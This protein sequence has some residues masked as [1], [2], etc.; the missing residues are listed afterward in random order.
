M[1]A[2]V[3]AGAAL[4]A[5][6]A[7][8]AAL[9]CS[10]P[11]GD[12]RFTAA[13]G[14]SSALRVSRIDGSRHYR[15]APA[16]GIAATGI[17]HLREP[18]TVAA[19]Q[20]LYLQYRATVAEA[21]VSVLDDRDREVARYRLQ[22]GGQA[23]IRRYLP[24]P[25][26][27]LWGFRLWTEEP[28]GRLDLTAAGVAAGRSGVAM[29]DGVLHVGVDVLLPRGT[30]V[31][32]G[33]LTALTARLQTARST[34]Q[35]G[36]GLVVRSTFIPDSAGGVGELL[37]AVSGG[38][39]AS[40]RRAIVA[41]VLAEGE[42]LVHL[43]EPVLGFV[44]TGV[45]A[46]SYT[47]GSVRFVELHRAAID[48]APLPADLKAILAYP[49]SAWRGADWEVFRWTALAEVLIFDTASYRIQEALFRRLA[50]FVEKAGFRGRVAS[51]AELAGRYGYNAHDYAAADVARFFTV[52]A[53][54]G[55]QLND[56]ELW[57]RDF[58]VA[59]GVI[60]TVGGTWEAG[61]GAVL[62]ISRESSPTLR[63]LLLRHEAAHG[64]YFVR[65]S[66]R[67][68]IASLWQEIGEPARAAWRA[69][70]SALGYDE[71]WEE[72]MMNEFQAYLAQHGEAALGYY[73]GVLVPSRIRSIRPAEQ[74]AAAWFKAGAQPIRS[75]H[76]GVDRALRSVAGMRA[77][78]LATVSLR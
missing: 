59:E 41:V 4:L 16:E 18:V 53:R 19:D 73:F 45:Q 33:G 21:T 77:G 24:L 68:R 25:P 57:L 8:L 17:V 7:A 23:P 70:L 69:Y 62:S 56:A 67:Q 49:Q 2:G 43:H 61:S 64:L 44:P 29:V 38:A 75:Q 11:A 5:S 10:L 20:A 12:A 34:P 13:D 9:G 32:A 60:R 26:G 37:L 35:P 72:L 39:D 30:Q 28:T 42:R 31:D 14:R 71:S 15:L 74:A 55:L 27:P 52:A 22:A 63:E 58:L 3:R 50:Y 78:R 51:D 36:G 1:K 48:T 76:R 40:A 6:C 46:L 66:Y 54:D 47:G 65:P